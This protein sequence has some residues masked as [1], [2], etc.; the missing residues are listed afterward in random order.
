MSPEQASAGEVDQR[1]DIFSL[2]VVLY[3]LLTGSTPFQADHE[4]AVLYR[5]MHSDPPPLSNYSDDFPEKLQHVID[6]ALQKVAKERFGSAHEFLD[7]LGELQSSLSGFPPMARAYRR[8]RFRSRSLR[9]AGIALVVVVVAAVVAVLLLQPR[10]AKPIESIAVLPL[11]DIS[12]NPA[13]EYFT[14]GM[15]E[16][17]ILN[18]SK[19]RGLRV[20]SRTSVMN[21]KDTSEPL[22]SIARKLG[23]DGVVEGSVL[24][25]GDRVQITAQLVDASSDATLWGE[26]FEADARDVLQLQRQVARAVARGIE[27]ELSPQEEV[28][29][30]IAGPIDPDAHA[31]Y[32]QGRFLWNQRSR[33]SVPK[34]IEFFEEALEKEP[35]FADAWTGL[36]EAY[37]ILQSYSTVSALE[38]YPKVLECATRALEIDSTS[39]AAYNALADAAYVYELNWEESEKLRKK[40]LELN[41]SYAT[42][43]QWYAEF[44]SAM[45]RHDEALSEIRLAQRLDPLSMILTVVEAGIMRVAR[46]YDDSIEVLLRAFERDSSFT[47]V[48]GGLRWSY[49]RIGDYDQTLEWQVRGMVVTGASDAEIDAVRSAYRNSGKAGLD[50]VSLDQLLERAKTERV[51]PRHLA[52]AH[53]RLGNKEEALYWLERSYEERGIVLLRPKINPDFDSMRDDPGF[54]ALM[55]RLRL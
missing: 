47:P 12:P 1:S 9:T 4:A 22:T 49:Y 31:A 5:I 32:L 43:H 37:A 54:Q 16:A 18:L 13:G 14:A 6:M 11:M 41:P 30:A 44:L 48:L 2:G 52:G 3:E 35:R 33:E 40:A 38:A 50:R 34:S 28:A 55:N 36:A 51:H 39:A 25:M 8:P 29:L 20:T 53:A 23:V 26:S 7:A 15:T 45:G 46:R 27:L 21:F 24:K 10:P 17:L 19:I 42:A